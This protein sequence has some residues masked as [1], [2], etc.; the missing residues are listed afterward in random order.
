[1]LQNCVHNRIPCRYVLN[2]IWFASAENMNYIKRTLGKEFIMG[3][4]TNRKIALS[5]Q[6]KQHGRYHRLHQLDLPEDTVTVIYLEQSA[7]SELHK[8]RWLDRCAYRPGRLFDS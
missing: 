6:D 7:P 5:R 3:L 8:R 2:D 1:M 4:K